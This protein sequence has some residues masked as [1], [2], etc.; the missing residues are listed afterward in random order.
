[1]KRHSIP[2]R[3]NWREKVEKLGFS[4]HTLDGAIYWDESAYYEFNYKQVGILEQA[5]NE[6][7]RLCLEAV[8]H[9]IENDLLD[10]FLVP[11]EFMPLVK[12]SW[13]LR[14]PSIYGRYDLSW[15]GDEKTAPK[16][17]EFNADTPTSLFEAS[18]IQWFWMQDL[19][20]E[21]DQFNAIHEKMIEGWKKMKPFLNDRPLYFSCL[22]EFPEDLINVL[23]MQ[24][25]AA[26]AGIPTEFINIH[27]VGRNINGFIDLEGKEIHTIFKL[28]PWEWLSSEDYA[29]LL[30]T[31]NTRWIEPSWKMILSNKAILPVLWELFPG[32]PN[33]L[34]CY[35]DDPGDMRSYARKPLLSREGAN[36]LLV[37][38]GVAACET[39]GEYGEEGYIYQQLQK[40]PA[41]ENNFPVIGSWIIDGQSAGIG[42]R[43]S[44]SLVTDNFSRFLPHVI[45]G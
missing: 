25:C 22:K 37:E 34:E 12:E 32:H 44:S 3:D 4:Y 42:I 6:L 14:S 5:T 29:D 31:A 16:M 10:L 15:N 41:F 36:I 26:Q 33:L 43:E 23:Y 19:F 8:G 27:D 38:N 18:V 17:L 11:G 1:M 21:A 30:L 20:P 40:L 7:Y 39:Q 2:A 45:R 24:D 28:Y 13:K 35:F 9:V